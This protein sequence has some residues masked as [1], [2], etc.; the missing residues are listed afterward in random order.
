MKTKKQLEERIT[1][2]DKIIERH[3]SCIVLR[4]DEIKFEEAKK[5]KYY[6]EQAIKYLYN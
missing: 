4:S 2:L 6:I 3:A 1:E 5:E